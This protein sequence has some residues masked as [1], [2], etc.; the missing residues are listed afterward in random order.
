MSLW[1]FRLIAGP[2]T[3]TNTPLIKAE[4]NSAVAR[5]AALGLNQNLPDSYT[6][7]HRF[8]IYSYKGL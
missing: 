4:G 7:S 8:T 6:F 3:L 1:L 2:P 5:N